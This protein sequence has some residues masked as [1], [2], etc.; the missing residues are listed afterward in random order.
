M[1]VPL[2]MDLG[3]EGELSMLGTSC[4]LAFFSRDSGVN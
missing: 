3:Q 1:K 2:L 4:V